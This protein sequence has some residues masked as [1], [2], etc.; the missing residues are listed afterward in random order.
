MCGGRE[1]MGNLCCPLNFIINL[2]LLLKSL[3]GKKGKR[4]ESDFFKYV[5]IILL[6][7]EGK[8]GGTII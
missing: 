4:S 1:P 7:T 3:G 2:K 8:I 6:C 5:P